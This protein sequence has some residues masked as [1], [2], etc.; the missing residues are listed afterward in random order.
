MWGTLP[1]T[2]WLTPGSAAF[3]IR[4]INENIEVLWPKRGENTIAI[5]DF[6]TIFESTYEST[7][8]GVGYIL[9]ITKRTL[10]PSV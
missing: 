4:W 1:A 2:L 7:H 3:K 10:K 5:V 9:N 6:H 8:V